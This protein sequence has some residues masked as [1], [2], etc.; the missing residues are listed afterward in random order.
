MPKNNPLT[1]VTGEILAA[2]L[3]AQAAG[4]DLLLAEMRALSEVLPG[5][6]GQVPALPAHVAAAEEADFDNMPV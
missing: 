3:S 4:M 2:T 6:L 1:E 5:S